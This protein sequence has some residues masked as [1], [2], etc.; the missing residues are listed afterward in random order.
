MS[1]L[2]IALP[3]KGWEEVTLGFLGHCGLRVDRSNPRQYRARMR[4]AFDAGAS[5]YL[6]W[7]YNERAPAGQCGLDFGPDSPLMRLFAEF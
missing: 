3:S 2:R 7:A 6:L 1:V 4:A 5:G